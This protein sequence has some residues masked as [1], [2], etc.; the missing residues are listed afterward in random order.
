MA[1]G[2]P[3]MSQEICPKFDGLKGSK[4]YEK[5]RIM[6]SLQYQKQST[7][8]TQQNFNPSGSI[9]PSLI[10]GLFLSQHWAI[11][12]Y[13]F[14][15]CKAQAFSIYVTLRDLQGKPDHGL[16]QCVCLFFIFAWYIFLFPLSFVFLDFVLGPPLRDRM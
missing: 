2:C 1:L 7:L 4:M 6:V 11:S 10:P 16:P 14:L 9:V 3:L 8:H 5:C 12:S 15:C 13:L